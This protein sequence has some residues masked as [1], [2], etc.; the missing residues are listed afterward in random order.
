MNRKKL[1]PKVRLFIIIGSL[2]LAIAATVGIMTL[3]T[4]YNYRFEGVVLKDGN[5]KA[6]PGT[7]LDEAADM[8]QKEGLIAKADQ[9]VK[10]AN[11]Y[12]LNEIKVGNY[13]LTQGMSY[14]TLLSALSY[15][16]QTPIKLTFNNFRTVDRLVGAVARKTLHD[17]SAMMKIMNSDSLITA[18][19]FS[20]ETLISMFI[21][22]TYEVYW[23]IT[24]EQ[25]FDKMWDEYDDFWGFSRSAKAE[26]LGFTRAEIATIASIVASETNKED[27]MGDVAGVYINRL[28]KKM[29]L[30][31][32]P[33]VKFA[34]QDFGLKRI[35][36][37]H[38]K[39]DSPYNTYKYPGLPPGPICMPSIAAIDATLNYD[40]HD[41][42]YF[43]AR[44]DFSGYHS[45]ARNM[46]EHSRNARAYHNE[47]NR[48]KIK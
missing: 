10:Y 9:M 43:C 7:T 29:P 26:K 27:E 1:K 6:Y 46:T 48:R 39:V 14:R 13:D 35:L 15:G 41:Y 3:V 16:R 28:H 12:E 44:A 42:L 37:K 45:F 19:G 17:S 20:K 36:N 25:F 2:I 23:T 33:T 38:L 5:F 21:P 11:R 8:L 34:L 32:D 40:G 18:R 24:P 30:Q 4:E 31:A 22:N 47:L